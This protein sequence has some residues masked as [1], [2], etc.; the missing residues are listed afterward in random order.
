M[1]VN[2]VYVGKKMKNDKRN[3]EKNNR[4]VPLHI[5]VCKHAC[6]IIIES[7]M[8]SEFSPETPP[9]ICVSVSQS[10]LCQEVNAV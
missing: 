10:D 3:E 5:Q 2:I 4:A 7:E 6:F 1:P 8:K 9:L